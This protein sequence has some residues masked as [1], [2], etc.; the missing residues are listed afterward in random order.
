M[1]DADEDLIKQYLEGDINTLKILI[2]RYTPIIYNFS[3]RFVGVDNAPDI[4]QD[5]FIK[6]WKNLKKFD[7]NKAH[8][9]T[10]LFTIARNT[11]TDYFR[12]KKSI[13]FSDLDGVEGESFTDTIEDDAILPDEAIQKIQDSDS[14]NELLSRLPENYKS[15]LV[16]YYQEDMTFDEIGKVLNKPLNTIKSQHRRALEQLRKMTL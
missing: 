13:V 9:K 2:D 3:M 10:W 4:V 5:T 15:V 1:L 8:F 16:L 6:V 12:K 7:I 11:I 14:L